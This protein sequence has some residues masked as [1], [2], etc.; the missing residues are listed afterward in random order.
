MDKKIC[1]IM[2]H[3]GHKIEC[4][5]EK[6]MAWGKIYRVRGSNANTYMGCKLIERKE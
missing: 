4:H 5:E 1:P 6:C 3:T 2:S